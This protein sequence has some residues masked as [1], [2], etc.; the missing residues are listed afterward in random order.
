M[1]YNKFNIIQLLDWSTILKTDDE[2]KNYKIR[3]FYEYFKEDL[4]DEVNLRHD[5]N[6]IFTNEELI[7][8]AYNMIYTLS[9]MEKMGKVHGEIST[10]H[11]FAT[12][13]RIFRISEMMDDKSSYPI[14][15]IKKYFLGYYKFNYLIVSIYKN[16]YIYH[17][18]NI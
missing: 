17:I 13:S 1:E 11:M 15:I 6:M 5:S 9:E 3:L 12:R 14:N 8:I 10:K 18:L 4:R 16:I 2:Y 7:T